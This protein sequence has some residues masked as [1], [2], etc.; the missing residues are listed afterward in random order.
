MDNRVMMAIR[1]C[2]ENGNGRIEECG[3]MKRIMPLNS[4]RWRAESQFRSSQ[5]EWDGVRVVC[6]LMR[7]PHRDL[8]QLCT[9]WPANKR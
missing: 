2:D 5:V 8:G 4:S 9:L 6:T 1:G 7:T 3:Q